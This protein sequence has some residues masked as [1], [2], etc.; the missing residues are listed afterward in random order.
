MSLSPATSP[1][2][3]EAVFDDVDL[4]SS[5]KSVTEVPS[6]LNKYAVGYRDVR[7]APGGPRTNAASWY[8]GLLGC[9]KPMMNFMNKTGKPTNLPKDQKGI[10]KYITPCRRSREEL[11]VSPPYGLFGF[12]LKHFLLQ[13]LKKTPQGPPKYPQSWTPLAHLNYKYK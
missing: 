9:L 12:V 6:G 11:E 13:I 4:N 8:D 1:I 10:K 2:P 5:S 7:S 3:D